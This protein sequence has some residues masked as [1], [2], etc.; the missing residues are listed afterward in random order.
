PTAADRLRLDVAVT[1]VREIYSWAGAHEFD[2]RD[3]TEIVGG[4]PIGTGAFGA[5]LMSI[6]G[7]ANAL[8]TYTGEVQAGGRTVME[9]GY[10]VSRESSHYQ[11]RTPAGW[12]VSGYDGTML[13]DPETNDLVQLSIRTEELPPETGS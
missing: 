12:V 8:F 10:R 1:P 2:D 6:F 5:F 9:F 13:A 7:N 11:I 4:G 3:L